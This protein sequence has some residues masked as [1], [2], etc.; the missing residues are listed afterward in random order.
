[1]NSH[2]GSLL[3]IPAMG[4]SAQPVPSPRPRVHPTAREGTED[5]GLCAE[6]PVSVSPEGP[7]YEGWWSSTPARE[8]GS[9]LEDPSQWPAQIREHPRTPVVDLRDGTVISTWD[10]VTCSSIPGYTIPDSLVGDTVVVVDADTGEVVESEV[11]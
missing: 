1:M 11:L 5:N 3:A 4:C 7:D 2:R 9:V 8:D 10:R 6:F